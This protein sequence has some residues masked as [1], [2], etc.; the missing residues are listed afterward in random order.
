MESREEKI[1]KLRN[2]IFGAADG[3]TLDETMCAI[4]MAQ[5]KIVANTVVGDEFEMLAVLSKYREM[6]DGAIPI[7]CADEKQKN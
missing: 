4:T 1:I 2:A 6:Q 3:L 5:S 7:Y